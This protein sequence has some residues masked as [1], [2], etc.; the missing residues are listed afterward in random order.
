MQRRATGPP[1]GCEP[2]RCDCAPE[3]PP[4]DAVCDRVCNGERPVLP[5]GCEPPRCDCPGP[6]ECEGPNP[7][8]CVNDAQCGAGEACVRAEGQCFPSSC[9]CNP[10]NGA[11]VC[12]RDCV[13]QCAPA[14][15]CP[16]ADAVC[17]RV[18]N[19]ERPVLPEGCELP[20]CDCPGPVEC[21]GP[22]PAGCVNDAQCGAGEACVRAEGQCFPSSCECNPENGAWVCTRDCVGQCAPAPECPP[23]DAVCDR[24]C[25]GERPVLPEGCELPRCDCP[26]EC[27]DPAQICEAQCAGE[28]I[29]VPP[30]CPQPRCD[31]GGNEVNCEACTPEALMAACMEA[32]LPRDVCLAN[33]EVAQVECEERF[34]PA[35][36]NDDCAQCARDALLEQCVR[37]GIDQRICLENLDRL[38]DDCQAR[39]CG[40][41]GGDDPVACCEALT[42]ECLACGAGMTVDDYCRENPETIGCPEAPCPDADG[43]GQCKPGRCCVQCRSAASVL[44]N[45]IPTL[46]RWN[47]PRN[48]ERMFHRSMR[49]MGRMRTE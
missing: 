25:N 31:C 21:E 39:F 3:C 2:P 43:D 28:N 1:E 42:A 27:P 46:R 45:G 35:D 32:G 14:P 30:E 36:D 37:N 41:G 12:T 40:D 19:G 18:C 4:A 34:C 7:A 29:D 9:E 44:P 16:P 49:H 38:V 6:V 48:S 13:G 5:E 8:G 24:V 23:A 15:E 22:N 33:L 47:R 20:R 10:E 17:D 26:P 11:W